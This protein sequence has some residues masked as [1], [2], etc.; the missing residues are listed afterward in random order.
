VRPHSLNGQQRETVRRLRYGDLVRLFRHRWGYV[1]P[2][3]DAGRGDLWL[4]VVNLSLAEAEPEK[5]MHHAIEVWAPWM[6]PEERVAYVRHVWGLDLYQRIQTGREI[7]QLLRLT[8][9]E[10]QSLKLWQFKPIDATD[11]ELTAHSKAM[12]RERRRAKSRANGVRSR[13]QYLADMAA[14]PKPWLALGITRRT[15]ERRRAA[16]S[17]PSA[18]Q[19]D[20]YLSAAAVAGLARRYLSANSVSR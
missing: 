8:N 6:T 19:P 7:G 13:Q 20:A 12:R 15:W 5:K 4:L 3:D 17:G 16:R 9:A 10:R 2:D 1:L 11:E 18:A 14:I